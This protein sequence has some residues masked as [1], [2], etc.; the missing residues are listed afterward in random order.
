MPLAKSQHEARAGTKGPPFR[1]TPASA[2]KGHTAG[3][4]KAEE[5]ARE[6]KTRTTMKAPRR[7]DPSDADTH[8]LV[9]L[10]AVA[11]VSQ[12]LARAGHLAG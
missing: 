2:G 11:V 12:G 3:E 5:V 10:N 8:E 4:G 6:D 7:A 9:L 1:G